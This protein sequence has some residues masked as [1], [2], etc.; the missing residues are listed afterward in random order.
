M[1]GGI[2][3][4]PAFLAMALACGVGLF[5]LMMIIGKL[6]EPL[7]P[8]HRHWLERRHRRRLARGSDS[9][10]EELRSIESA[11]ARD[12]PIRGKLG[13]LDYALGLL[14]AVVAGTQILVWFV[15][16]TERPGWTEHMSTSIFILLG[17]Q[18]ATGNGG[19]TGAPTR[20]TRLMGLAMVAL[21][22]AFLILGLSKMGGAS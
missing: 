12:N 20:A 15:P 2:V 13:T 16:E 9:Y 4:T 10:F 21:F 14:F 7:G 1:G 6:A 19:L 11:L 3:S 22:S 18:M 5:A 17:I 8:L